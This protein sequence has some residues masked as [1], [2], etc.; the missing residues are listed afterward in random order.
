MSSAD[1]QQKIQVFQ[2]VLK[3]M[4][5]DTIRDVDKLLEFYKANTKEKNDTIQ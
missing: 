2:K 3:K 4:D 1:R 5:V